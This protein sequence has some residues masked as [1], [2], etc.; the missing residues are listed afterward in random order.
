MTKNTTPLKLSKNPFFMQNTKGS[1]LS[2]IRFY[3]ELKLAD[4]KFVAQNQ[5]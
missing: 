2:K 3:G 5:G 1:I 4:K